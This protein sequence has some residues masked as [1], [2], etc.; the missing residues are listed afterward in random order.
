M[1]DLQ[2]D[3]QV[4]DISGVA[5]TLQGNG[6]A[7]Q[8]QSQF[9]PGP[10]PQP[11]VGSPAGGALPRSESVPYYERPAPVEKS[12]EMETLP[13]P[14]AP[15]PKSMDEEAPEEVLPRSSGRVLDQRS[16]TPQETITTIGDLDP[17]TKYADEEENRFIQGVKTEHG[18]VKP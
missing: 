17:N 13:K 5:D 12:V 16:A 10:P 1:A 18:P 3:T 15:K 6:S 14:V 9:Q 7:V 4:L 11:N 2:D 8:P